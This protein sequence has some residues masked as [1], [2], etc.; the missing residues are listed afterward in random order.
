M[1][2]RRPGRR[3]GL[4]T[5]RGGASP[6]PP[7]SL[8][9]QL[10]ALGMAAVYW[11]KV[12]PITVPPG[13]TPTQWQLPDG[14]VEVRDPGN[15][16]GRTDDYTTNA[17]HAGIANQAHRPAYQTAGGLHFYLPDGTDDHL[18]CSMDI[19]GL[20]IP[21]PNTI[22]FAFRKPA[23]NNR[24]VCDGASTGR[25]HLIKSTSG[26]D[27]EFFAGTSMFCGPLVTGADYS[28]VCIANGAN[29]KVYQNSD[30]HPGDAGTVG[31]HGIVIG[32]DVLSARVWGDR[33]YG[34]FVAP[35]EMTETQ[36]LTIGK[37]WLDEISGG[38]HT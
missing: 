10:L 11:P 25:R 29:S 32:A 7:P 30:V 36:I 24:V 26:G 19:W 2:P 38:P 23:A 35:F 4:A 20:E 18:I 21:Q 27:L 31:M 14:S 15:P 1:M 37:P 33:I 9:E 5:T 12:P 34:G 16:I 22:G 8:L 28:V 13:L 17:R 3:I 6:P